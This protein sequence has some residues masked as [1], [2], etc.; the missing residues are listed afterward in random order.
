MNDQVPYTTNVVT[1]GV[2]QRTDVL[3][4]ANAPLSNSAFWMRSNLS[5]LCSYTTQGNALAAIYYDK[6]DTT[7]AP[8]STAW[9]VPD[10]GTCGNDDLSKTVPYF[11]ITPPSVPATTKTITINAVVNATGHLIWTMNGQT[12]HADYNNP[13]LL[14]ASQGNTSYPNHPEW[15]VQD[16]GSNS[17]IRV[18]LQNPTAAS[19]PM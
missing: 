14:L 1:L 2:G 6:A 19:H 11:P 10:S 16:F 18:I 7:L 5:E 15:N 12:F 3:V 13:L 8:S 9:N 4:T 17:S